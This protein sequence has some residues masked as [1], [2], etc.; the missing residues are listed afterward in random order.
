MLMAGKPARLAGIVHKSDKYISSG[1]FVFSPKPNAGV[2]VVGD[3][4]KSTLSNAV[5]KLVIIFD[6]TFKA[7][8]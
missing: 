3:K 4:I 6:L 1:F 8:P 7:L 5:L 2:G